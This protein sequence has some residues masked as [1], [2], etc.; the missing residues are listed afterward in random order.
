MI[1]SQRFDGYTPNLENDDRAS[2]GFDYDLI[3]EHLSGLDEVQISEHRTLERSPRAEFCTQAL[4]YIR[5]D[6]RSR[7][8]LDSLFVLMGLETLADV[9][10]KFGMS[11]EAIRKRLLKFRLLIGDDLFRKLNVD[12]RE[13][14][15]RILRYVRYGSRARLTV[16]CLFIA[17]NGEQIG[18]VT[19]A[20]IARQHGLTTQM[21]SK[22]VQQVQLDLRLPACRYNKSEA[23]RISYAKYNRRPCRAPEETN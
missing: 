19:M 18:G 11:I 14:I 23:S 21:I 7:V 1:P 3:D 4:I 13:F 6:S 10:R 22:R 8:A 5:E 15:L 17:M 20:E 12:D 2:E 16:D 9:G